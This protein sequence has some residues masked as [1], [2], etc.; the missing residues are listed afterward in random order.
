V[1]NDNIKLGSKVT[2]KG[3]EDSERIWEVIQLGDI[4]ELKD[5][6]RGWKVGGL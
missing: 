2:L 4:K 6:P 1:E 3:S 5:I